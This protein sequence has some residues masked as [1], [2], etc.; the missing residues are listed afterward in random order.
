[1]IRRHLHLQG[2]QRNAHIFVVE[3]TFVVQRGKEEGR[4]SSH[5][6]MEEW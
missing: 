2:N 5:F 6:E 1:M 3:V 4:I